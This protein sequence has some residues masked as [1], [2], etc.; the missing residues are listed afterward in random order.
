MLLRRLIEYS[1]QIDMPPVMYTRTPVKWLIDLA[2]DGRFLG[3]IMQ[4]GHGRRADRGKELL[5]PDPGRRTVKIKPRLLC[6]NAEYVLGLVPE[7]KKADRVAE[8]HRS[9]SQLIE[10]AAGNI[11]LPELEAVNEFLRSLPDGLPDLPE[12][13]EA[14]HNITFRANDELVMAHP[15]VQKWWAEY[16]GT[17]S[18]E[19]AQCVIC[20]KIR[21][22]LE[23]HPVAI[24]RVPG[25]QTSGMAMVSANV[26]A[27]LSY[28][29]SA[30]M[31]APTC[32]DCAERYA[33]SLNQLLSSES[34]SYRIG[35]TAFVFWTKEETDFDVL[36]FLDQ[37]D[38]DQ[39][40][41][42][43]RS[44]FTGKSYE[45]VEANAF[46]AAALSASGARLVVR[47][48]TETTVSNV[49][50]NLARWFR[51][52]HMTDAWGA[53]G[54]PLGIYALVSSLYRD[55]GR[56][57]VPSVPRLLVKS[58]L[59]GTPLPDYL[60]YQ[61]IKRMRADPNPARNDREDSFTMYSRMM[62]IR[63]VFNSHPDK[64]ETF[65]SN[66]DI[67]NREPAYICGRLLAVLESIQ[68]QAIPG[69]KATLI[70]RYYGA[71]SAAPASV[72]GTLMRG[73]Q[74]HLAKL[75]KEKE[76]AY[77]ALQNRLMDIY[78]GLSEWPSTLSMKE[79]A[80]FALGYYHQRADDRARAREHSEEKK[81]SQENPE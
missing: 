62:L 14:S 61:A 12:G 75:R 1:E 29:L 80:I 27:F 54:R 58:A 77:Y 24:K 53:E 37:P 52:Q 42:L 68:H 49:Q 70:D 60:L 67:N 17:E 69:A 79:Q 15:E 76:G 6:D 41:E 10:K 30:S 39:V 28:G 74:P 43:L 25:G 38:T 8:Q 3:F 26:D 46:Y 20:G 5:A 44:G 56:E 34:N 19:I 73:A 16:A 40:K 50:A 45:S 22:C 36:S 47:D 63:L 57:M 65:M 35:N 48:W 2:A 59:T 4:E 72:F 51:R 31:I 11:D 21:P 71:A 9:F 23:R 13:M 81:K 33:K 7:G 66:M 78:S 18:G 32:L 55:I 64:E